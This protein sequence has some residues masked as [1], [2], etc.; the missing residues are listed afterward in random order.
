MAGL[1][2]NSGVLKRQSVYKAGSDATHRITRLFRVRTPQRLQLF[3]LYKE[4]NPRCLA[5][6]GFRDGF[7]RDLHKQAACYPQ[8]IN[9]HK[10]R[11]VLFSELYC[12][13]Y[14]TTTLTQITTTQH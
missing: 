1:G 7:E 11:L 6:V 3:F 4:L 14:T 13:S 8:Q 5:Q 10:D 9:I 2:P 12:T